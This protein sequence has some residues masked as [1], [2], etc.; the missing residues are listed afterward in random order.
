VSNSIFV[1]NRIKLVLG[2][3]VVIGLGLASREFDGLFPDFLG[4]YPG[5][6]LWA[7]AAYVAWAIV[8]PGAEPKKLLWITFV[9]SFLVELSQLY[10]APWID[11]LRRYVIVHLFLGN[12]FNAID[13][14]AYMV[15]T[16]C[17]FVVDGLFYKSNAANTQGVGTTNAQQ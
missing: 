14:V 2:L 3:W 15:G 11:D 6:A 17:V 10:H 4:K 16:L 9:T 5:D 13:L 12:T 8:L 1:R 7:I